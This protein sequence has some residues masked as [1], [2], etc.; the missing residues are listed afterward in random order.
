MIAQNRL[1]GKVLNNSGEPVVG[2]TLQIEGT[3]RGA[4]SEADGSFSIS[5]DPKV[6]SFV[7]K[8]SAMGFKQQ[9]VTVNPQTQSF[10]QG[11]SIVL[12]SS[13]TEMESVTVS[14][15]S[16]TVGSVASLYQAQRTA[17]SI[18]DGI[19]AEVIRKAPDRNTGE[20]LKRI[21]GTTIQDNKF[22]II[23]GSATAITSAYL[24]ARCCQVPNLTGRHF[25]STSFLP[26]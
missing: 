6:A 21:S 19:S 3:N 16:R 8:V 18:S 1:T 9:N 4:I 11:L 14:A 5:T 20:V 7:I 2:A 10:E 25:L 17:A 15:R 12:Q 23:R 26:R 24:M 13:A 22:V